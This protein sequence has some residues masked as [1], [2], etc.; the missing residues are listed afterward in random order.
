EYGK[1]G[2][3]L[4]VERVLDALRVGGV[5]NSSSESWTTSARRVLWGCLAVDLGSSSISSRRKR[6][7]LLGEALFFLVLAEVAVEADA[8]RLRGVFSGDCCFAT[9]VRGAA[10][11]V[12]LPRLPVPVDTEA[13][14]KAALSAP[15]SGGLVL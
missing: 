9:P 13:P 5:G 7:A 15:P 14:S 6:G 1:D 8:G 2:R 4:G 12:E 11:R 10:R 3:G